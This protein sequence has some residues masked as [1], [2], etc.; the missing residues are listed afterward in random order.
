VD[1]D[2][3]PITFDDRYYFSY[4]VDSTMKILEINAA[5]QQSPPPYFLRVFGDDPMYEFTQTN[6]RLID[7]AALRAQH[8]IILNEVDNLSSG[9]TEELYKF[10]DN[11]GSVLLVPGKSIDG[12][13]LNAFTRLFQGPEFSTVVEQETRVS[14]IDTEA[15]FF[16][17]L[18]ERIPRN[19]DLPKVLSYYKLNSRV[20]GKDRTLMRLRTGDPFFSLTPHGSGNLYVSAVPLSTDKNNF[21]RHAIFVATT[22]RMSELSRPSVALSYDLSE[23]VTIS[24]G[25]KTPRGNDVFRIEKLDGS[26]E[27]IPEYS[28]INGRGFLFVRDHLQEA[29]NYLLKLGDESLMGLAFNYPRTESK[30]EYFTTAQMRNRLDERG[31]TD[32]SILNKTGDALEASLM[33]LESG[34]KLWKIFLLIALC[35]VLVETLLLKFWKS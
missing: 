21:A 32:V 8:F 5:Q 25:N 11:G 12:P 10:V 3:Y 35:F 2:D 31:L 23:E 16:A 19:M 15:P 29:G 26:F 17:N 22:L 33:D 18:F 1:I 6:V 28:N 27:M 24:T 7:Y 4:S 34:K 13:G 14:E 30:L 9:L 20:T